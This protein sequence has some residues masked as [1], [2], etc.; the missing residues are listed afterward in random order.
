MVETVGVGQAEVDVARMAHTTIVVEAP[1]L[2]DDVQ[3]LK[4]G[5]MEI[6]DIFVVNKADLPGADAVVN[7]LRARIGIGRRE[8]GVRR[9]SFPADGR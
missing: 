6:A 3:T 5:I 1:G 2:G 4:A 9:P 8:A 7:A